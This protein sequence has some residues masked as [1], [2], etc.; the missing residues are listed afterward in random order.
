MTVLLGSV[1]FIQ[2]FTAGNIRVRSLGQSLPDPKRLLKIYFQAWS[3]GTIEC[4]T[5]DPQYRG[6]QGPDDMTSQVYRELKSNGAL[7]RLISLLT[8]DHSHLEAGPLLQQASREYK[9]A[10]DS[11]ED[12]MGLISSGD[13]DTSSSRQLLAQLLMGT[14]L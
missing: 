11:N 10:M 14:R 9:R 4:Y 5:C 13:S 7:E 3:C 8:S 12:F 2:G 1:R 6:L